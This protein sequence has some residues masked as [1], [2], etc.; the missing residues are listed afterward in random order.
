[1]KIV[2]PAHQASGGIGTVVRGLVDHLP[3]A[4]PSGVDL[5]V[6]V[7]NGGERGQLADRLS[8]IWFEQVELARV[9]GGD[10]LHLPDHRPIIRSRAPFSI[11]IHDV[12]FLDHPE[13]FPWSVGV[14]KRRMLDAA[15]RM[16][17]RRVICVSDYARSRL[18]VHYPALE[19]A[20]VVIH[21]G[22]EQAALVREAGSASGSYFLTLSTIE[23]RKNHL[24]LLRAFAAARSAGLDLRWKVVGRP[25]YRSRAIV[26]KLKGAP[27][28][29]VIGH[30]DAARLDT[31]IGNASFVACPSIAEGFG[32]PPL[33]AMVR[34]VPVCCSTGSALDET[35]GDA[36]LRV[37]P[38]DVS[39][40]TNALVSLAADGA[41]KASLAELGRRQVE[42]FAW[43]VAAT[44]YAEELTSGA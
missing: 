33:E 26:D 3:S 15:V 31:L 24:T 13:W 40:W 28:V 44:R 18:L 23:P 35:V 36:A 29:D 19:A 10:V 22:V 7:S 14:Y 41:L 43:S 6:V 20:A 32:F 4:L 38:F 34:G 5:E 21:S 8:R 16:G 42:R 30:A 37:E 17:P 12:F 27:G 2:F 25:G 39:G 11:T 1:M 9:N